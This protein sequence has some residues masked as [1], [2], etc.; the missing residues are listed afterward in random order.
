MNTINLRL[1]ALREVH[2][3]E[4]CDIPQLVAELTV[5]NDSLNIQV[6][7]SLHHVGK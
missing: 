4:L 7:V 6:D 5:A 3:A 1:E 2:E